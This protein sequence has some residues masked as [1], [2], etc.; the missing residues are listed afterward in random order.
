[1]ERFKLKVAVYLLL[2]K[3]DKVLL[4][5]RF[6]TG[7]QDGNYGLPSGHL[8]P[9]E[10]VIEALLRET[11]EE[12][13]I[14][15]NQEDIK[16]VHTMHRA[17]NYIDLFFVA[18]SWIGELKNMESD[19]CDDLQWFSLNALPE[20][21]VPSVKFAIQNYQNGVLFSELESES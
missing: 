10:M 21:I 15:L 6:H 12:I 2:I 7:W 14:K 13:G 8:E 5:R 19:K 20:N 3:E 16:F 4:L 1:M 9:N 18:K 11:T 17:S